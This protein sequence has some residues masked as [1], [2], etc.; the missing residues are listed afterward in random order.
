MTEASCS[1][2]SS[3]SRSL[4]PALLVAGVSL[5]ACQKTPPATA[6]SEEVAIPSAAASS[7]AAAPSAASPTAEVDAGLGL[8]AL[9]DHGSLRPTPMSS[10]ING[11][12]DTPDSGAGFVGQVTMG[13]VTVTKGALTSH[14]RVLAGVRPRLRSCYSR[15]LQLDPLQKGEVTL[16]LD[17]ATNG[18]VSGASATG[19]LSP[20]VLACMKSAGQHLA[21][22]PPAAPAQLS[23]KYTCS[24]QK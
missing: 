11:H 2:I 5:L 23:A 4:L 19:P 10:S 16:V 17:V 3:S 6:T 15:G 8:S 21:F 24:P 14:E 12:S 7:V 18:E 1:A 22:D 20:A 9:Q 13:A